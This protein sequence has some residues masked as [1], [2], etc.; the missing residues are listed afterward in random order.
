MPV[1]AIALRRV[2]IGVG[3]AGNVE[4]DTGQCPPIQ[5]GKK[6]IALLRSNETSELW[7]QA[8]RPYCSGF[9]SLPLLIK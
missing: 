5:M 1:R 2:G 3:L 8:L 6:A 4:L 9:I 7:A